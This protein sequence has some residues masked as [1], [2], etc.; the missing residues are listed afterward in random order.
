MLF[1]KC[2]KAVTTA[3]HSKVLKGNKHLTCYQTELTT[4]GTRNVCKEQDTDP[5]RAQEKKELCQISFDGIQ[6]TQ[7]VICRR[8][9]RLSLIHI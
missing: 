8:L 6:R 4:N 5:E 1:R 9:Y 7:L 2:I 3:A